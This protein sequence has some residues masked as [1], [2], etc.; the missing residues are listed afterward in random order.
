ME[1]I[2][3]VV[4]CSMHGYVSYP[5]CTRCDKPDKALGGGSIDGRPV[6]AYCYIK[7]IMCEY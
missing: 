3:S 4:G 7:W 1:I 5:P 2:N 6:C